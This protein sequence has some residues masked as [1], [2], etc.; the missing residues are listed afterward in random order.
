MYAARSDSIRIRA[1]EAVMRGMRT[2]SRIG[3]LA[4]VVVVAEIYRGFA[5]AIGRR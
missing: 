5:V 1:G 3:V 2:W 4:P